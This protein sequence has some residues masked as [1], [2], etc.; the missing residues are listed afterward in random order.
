M[1]LYNNLFGVNPYAIL[2]L[3]ILGTNYRLVP[4]FR[5]VYVKDGEIV[6]Y[7]RTGGGNRDYYDF[8]EGPSNAD[9]RQLSGYL[10]DEDDPHDPTF[11]HFYY[12]VP[13]RHRSVVTE[14]A[15][16]TV[17]RPVPTEMWLKLFH[18]LDHSNDTPETAR[19]KEIGR[20]IIGRLTD[21]QS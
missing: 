2:L 9:L 16:A 18:D 20:Q 11:A 14:I 13:E 15:E 4:R 7:T 3:G 6:L 17:D 8:C 10:R 1:S 19:A 12:A 5:D 21:D